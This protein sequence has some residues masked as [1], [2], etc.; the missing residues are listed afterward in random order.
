[1]VEAAVTTVTM[2]GDTVT[3]GQPKVQ[4]HINDSSNLL[5]KKRALQR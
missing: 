4:M 5:L 2:F 3:A 1:M